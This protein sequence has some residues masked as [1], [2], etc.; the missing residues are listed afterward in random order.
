VYILSIVKQYFPTYSD[1]IVHQIEHKIKSSYSFSK[2]LS[3]NFLK[4]DRQTSLP[5]SWSLRYDYC[6]SKQWVDNYN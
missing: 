6:K 5:L 2:T 3:E 4:V 1:P